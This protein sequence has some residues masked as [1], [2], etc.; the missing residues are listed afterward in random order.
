MQQLKATKQRTFTRLR[1]VTAND[2]ST[3][4]KLALAKCRSAYSAYRTK[5]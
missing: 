2:T 5:F 3:S 1:V 4:M